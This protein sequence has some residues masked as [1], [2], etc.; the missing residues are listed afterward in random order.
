MKQKSNYRKQL[1]KAAI[2]FSIMIGAGSLVSAVALPNVVEATQQHKV[3]KGKITDEKGEGIPGA[4]IVVKG[5]TT[6]VV[7]DVDGNYSISVPNNNAV[8]V[9]SFIGSKTKEVAVAGKS[10]VNVSLES[11]VEELK[12]VVVTALGIK[13][14][15][16]SLGYAVQDV[17]SDELTKVGSS[18]LAD[19]LQGKV[20]GLN[21]SD[22]GTGAG[23]SAKIVIRGN[24][25][26][27]DNNEPLWVVDGV[28]YDSAP[29]TDNMQWG[30]FDRAGGSFD[31][32]PEDVE[33]I[34]VLKG[35]TAAALY[36]SRAGNGVIL[37]TT[38]KGG[39]D[40]KFGISYSGKFTFS[41]AAYSLDEQD[42]YGQG[43][44]GVFSLDQNG[45]WGPEMK[46]Q[47]VAAWW[48]NT[49]TTTFNVQKDVIKNF[50]RTGNTQ[51]NNLTIAGGDK[52]NPFRLSIGHDYTKGVMPRNNVA[53]TSFDLVT[54]YTLNKY[55][56][57]D[58]KA[59][60][61]NVVGECRPELGFY[62]TMFYLYTMPRNIQLSDLYAY[63][64]NPAELAA[65]THTQMNWS[66]VVNADRQNPYFII[67]DWNNK[68]KKNR[69]FGMVQATI[70][71]TPELTLKLKQG[72]DYSSNEYD[73]VYD[74]ADGIF[75]GRPMSQETKSSSNEL[76]S[77]FLLSYNKTFGDF[78]VGLSG[79]GNRM[80]QRYDGLFGKGALI[81]FPN[82]HYLAA[83]T[84]QT[85]SND[86]SEREINSLYAFANL[87]YKDYLYLD[88]T[89]RNDWSSTLPSN[90]RSYFY[91]S[92]GIS[93]IVT[94]AMDAMNINYNKKLINYGKVRF[95]IAQVGKDT[96]P[97]RLINTYGTTTDDAH[98]LLYTTEP[99]ELANVNLKP[100][101]STSW[102]VG[103]EW[104]LFNNRFGFDFTYYDM[105][106]KNQVLSIPKVYSTGY[107]SQVVNVGKISNKGIELAMNATAVKTK[108]FTLDL[109]LNFAH[110]Y[111]KV[112]E[113][114]PLI[115]K[116]ELG[117][118][119]NGVAV[120]A[121]QGDKLGEIWAKGYKY[122]DKGNKVIG[123]DGL[124]EKSDERVLGS[125]QP[126]F[127]GSFGINAAYKG[128]ALSALFN[129]QKGGDIYSFTED[130]AA[131]AGVAK[132]TA[133]RT[134]RV[135]AGVT[136]AGGTNTTSITAE[137]YWQN[138]TN[139][140]TFLYDASFLKLKEL[141]LSYTFNKKQLS[142]LTHNIINNLKFSLFGSN[143]FYL[144]KHT[145]GT[146]PDGSAFSANMFSQAIDFSPVPNLRNIGFSINVGF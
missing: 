34:S 55:V 110:N 69:F 145:P 116:Y 16:K 122:D 142:L 24:S 129:F 80:Y 106:T 50:M 38:K 4:S 135:I 131:A 19:A 3:V 121:I 15:K 61:I 57:F 85:T 37:V 136:E 47:S 23:G 49:K 14:E 35:P 63:R 5:S 6:G 21:I 39:K 48:D 108:D 70:H 91:P 20:A 58:V 123:D 1:T 120:V 89:A 22:A 75:E 86:I 36:G 105:M 144:V 54:R 42:I 2:V 84:T 7:S 44:N 119:N 140:E 83:G 94:S 11:S 117:S 104:R 68:D 45:S 82:T 143:L 32:N 132:C 78:Q 65:G 59:N 137:N 30:G 66:S 113:L 111:T 118:L 41:K 17:K 127:T 130:E 134:N 10:V 138:G 62:S 112:K 64:Y 97:Y 99:T 98:Q 9:V 13:R 76:N 146:T 125:I 93:V 53:K 73:E 77:E 26:L 107:S 74:Y 126:D 114:D 67:D 27:S 102:E 60:Y 52:D 25:S 115:D 100:E 87:G 92:A 72:I 12:E 101:I 56:T 71:F 128:F 141:A 29:E 8:I 46:G 79:G 90:N 95:S 40:G 28:P 124:P 96:D 31:L 18:G 133:D 103:T 43:S 51:S 109:L 33:S 81:P 139:P 88:L